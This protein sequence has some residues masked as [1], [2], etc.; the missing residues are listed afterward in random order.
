MRCATGAGATAAS[1]R[2]TR[3]FEGLRNRRRLRMHG[4]EREAAVRFQPS[5]HVR[6][7]RGVER[8]VLGEHADRVD[9]IEPRRRELVAEEV[10]FD[11][12][13]RRPP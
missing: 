2:P 4:R 13:R 10:A 7:D 8:H 6:D 1:E 11:E 12:R 5:R 9:E 3:R